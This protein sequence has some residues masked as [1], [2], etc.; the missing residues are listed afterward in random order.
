MSISRRKKL[1]GNETEA[2]LETRQLL[3]DS[4]KQ[5]WNSEAGQL[6]KLEM[7]LARSGVQSSEQAKKRISSANR[8]ALAPASVRIRMSEAQNRR[9]DR[10]RAARF[11][12]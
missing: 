9:R 5:F 8:K 7:S 1:T 2:E 11:G 10:E 3:S 12:L 6:K 4:L